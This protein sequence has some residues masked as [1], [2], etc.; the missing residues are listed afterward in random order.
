MNLA[1]DS[2]FLLENELKKVNSIIERLELE[3]DI[4]TCNKYSYQNYLFDKN[5]D[6]LISFSNYSKKKS[7]SKK[8]KS[9]FGHSTVKLNYNNK[10]I[11]KVSDKNKKLTKNEK[12]ISKK[13]GKRGKIKKKTSNE[14]ENDNKYFINNGLIN[15]TNSNLE[16]IT[17]SE[18]DRKIG[19]KEPVYCF[20]NYVSY[21]NMIKCD[22][23]K[24]KKEWFHFHCVGLR[25]LPKGKW[26]CSEKCANQYKN[27]NKK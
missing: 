9:A 17:Y 21:G 25:N 6:E 14:N 12:K 13:I 24:C 8:T 26:F 11:E 10:I 2:Y 18:I 4:N 5:I 20:C 7:K 1:N 16:D 19:P 3:Q 23:P 27:L 15:D 22:N